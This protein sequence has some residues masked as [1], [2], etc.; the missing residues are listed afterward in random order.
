MV[1]MMT[2]PATARS[3]SA[4]WC[5]RRTNGAASWLAAARSD[6]TWKGKIQK[7]LGVEYLPRA[8]SGWSD[9]DKLKEK[10][11]EL[12]IDT[13]GTKKF[14]KKADKLGEGEK[15][16]A[17]GI[18][19]AAVR[20]EA[21]YLART[22]RDVLKADVATFEKA[23]NDSITG[24]ALKQE[25]FDALVSLAFNIGASNFK[26]STLVRKINEN[27]YRNGTDTGARD[28]AIDEIAKAFGAW[29]KS[30]GKV[31]SG[32]TK[33]REAEA[34]MFLTGAKEENNLLK[35]KGKAKP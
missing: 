24:V 25:E 2:R 34:G 4:T 12:G 6:D 16:T 35:A 1:S 19:E 20:D 23:V 9:L 22:V 30:G 10:A 28:K 17:K 15:K 31:L 7:T 21:A 3:V 18:A 32:L 29:N 14:A 26:S 33:R 11:I 13:V 8:A 27:K 5:T